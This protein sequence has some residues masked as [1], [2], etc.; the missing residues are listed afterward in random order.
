MTLGVPAGQQ[1]GGKVPWSVTCWP[2]ASTLSPTD[3]SRPQP[4]AATRP[5]PQGAASPATQGPWGTLASP[6]ATEARASVT[7]TQL[8]FQLSSAPVVRP[9]LC[10]PRGRREP[11]FSVGLPAPRGAAWSCRE[12]LAPWG[13]RHCSEKGGGLTLPSSKNPS[14]STAT[15]PPRTL[16]VRFPLDPCPLPP[17]GPAPRH[18]AR[19]P[20]WPETPSCPP[21][22]PD[23]ALRTSSASLG[24]R[25]LPNTAPRLQAWDP[26]S[27]ERGQQRPGV[28][29]CW[30][31]G[32]DVCWYGDV[33]VQARTHTRGG[34]AV[35]HPLP[36][37]L[38]QPQES[39]GVGCGQPFWTS[40]QPHAEVHGPSPGHTAPRPPRS[41][42]GPGSPR[43]RGSECAQAQALH[44]PPF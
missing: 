31:G 9:A 33:Y 3:S 24:P 40:S 14:G 37:S 22:C 38:T 7:P 13:W 35:G 15:C 41:A 1:R 12:P 5:C 30:G 8:G 4:R 6:P 11:C 17:P 34:C 19:L 43:D 32:S 23:S 27:Q 2:P 26:L 44:F 39:L 20:H 10:T 36:T 25:G 42:R 29:S 21:G 18:T 16:G 28:G